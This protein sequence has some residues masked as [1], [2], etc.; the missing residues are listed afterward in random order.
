MTGYKISRFTLAEPLPGGRV[1]LFSTLTGA[2]GVLPAQ[3]WGRVVRNGQQG[4]RF[5]RGL[6]EQGFLVEEGLDEDAVL[7]HWRTARLYD[8][9]RP[10]FLVRL[11]RSCR[12][13]CP[14][15]AYGRPG[16]NG[17][18]E[19]STARGVLDFIQ[20]EIEGK[21]PR[22]VSLEFLPPEPLLNLEVL[23]YLT[24]GLGRFCRGGRI[25]LHV[26][27]SVTG[28]GLDPAVLEA[29]QPFGLEAVEAVLD[30]PA[31]VH[32]RRRPDHEGG[33]THDRVLQGLAGL[34]GG[35]QMAW[36]GFFDPAGDEYRRLPELLAD[37]ERAGFKGSSGGVSFHP[38]PLEGRS[39]CPWPRE[40]L[41]DWDSSRALW[42][43][44]ALSAAGFLPPGPP[45]VRCPGDY[46]GVTV[47]EPE[48]TL[49]SCPAAVDGDGF[50]YGHV[51]SG[52][53]FRR[54]AVLSVRRLSE[55]CR[56]GCPVAPLCDGGCR[57]R[58]LR[59]QGCF[60]G[61]VCHRDTLLELSCAYVR[62][63]VA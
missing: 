55:E 4:D 56:S 28:L 31:D 44:E 12:L 39:G 52:R 14:D 36:R 9:S 40:C 24:E 60:D 10:R 11:N 7:A 25:P 33:F 54:Q 62:T 38:E 51:L 58:G 46:Q 18:M 21:R 37:L 2:L 42:V 63:S 29:L 34:K 30:G 59:E 20:A 47:I 23:S 57:L 45:A 61:V 27:L 48:G 43:R 50:D 6:R 15:C 35:F 49:R 22:E 19:L 32:D 5:L 41:A 17:A 16:G 13:A 3:V 1:G 8:L 53:D 26:R